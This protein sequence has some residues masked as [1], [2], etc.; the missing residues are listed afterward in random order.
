MIRLRTLGVA[1]ML[2]LLGLLVGPH[3]A[4]A[5]IVIS[6]PPGGLP[7][8]GTAPSDATFITQIPNAT[9]T[10]EQALDA[11][12]SGIMRVDTA[13]GVITSLTDSAGIA[14]NLSDETGTSL[15]VFNTNPVLVTP[16]L[17][18]P[19]AGVLTNATG[20]PISTGVSGLGTNVATFL[21]TPSSVNLIAALTDETGTGAAV[22]GT[23]PQFTTAIGIGTAAASI[24]LAIGDSDTGLNQTADGVLNIVA[25]NVAAAIAQTDG[26]NIRFFLP[27]VDDDAAENPV[28][29]SAAGELSRGSAGCNISSRRYKTNI[30]DMPYGLAEVLRLRPVTFEKISTPDRRRMGLVAE[31]VAEIFPD[32]IGY[33]PDDPTLVQ[34]Y[35]YREMH[36]L[37]VKAIQEQQ[38][39]IDTLQRRLTR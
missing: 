5:Q 10:N 13:A 7:G 8:G 32:M 6:P 26:S 3:L 30:Q 28:C 36:A 35:D 39:Q 19:S 2:G 34:T 21:A 22:F 11:L 16:D 27:S 33:E 29:R 20:L 25:Q 23:S 15:L 4:S 14:A 31:D 1:L 17:G 18:T 37:L 9:L 12:A 24:D 38:D